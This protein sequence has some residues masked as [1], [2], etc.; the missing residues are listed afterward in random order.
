MINEEAV[1]RAFNLSMT[2]K[3]T[4]KAVAKPIYNEAKGGEPQKI[5]VDP[6]QYIAN[7]DYQCPGYTGSST[8]IR[9][10]PGWHM[11]CQPL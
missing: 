6:T 3:C 4:V 9:S 11:N 7:H 5:R 1:K 10:Y 8:D 2:C